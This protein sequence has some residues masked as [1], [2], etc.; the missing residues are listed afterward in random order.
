ML[1]YGKWADHLE[2]VIT[3]KRDGIG[4]DWIKAMRDWQK[5]KS[6]N[7]MDSLHC[8]SYFKRFIKMFS[9]IVT[10]LTNIKRIGMGTNIW[11]DYTDETFLILKNCIIYD[12]TPIS[13]KWDRNYRGYV[14]ASQL[15][16]WA[17]L[18]QINVDVVRRVRDYYKTIF[19][20]RKVLYSKSPRVT[21]TFSSS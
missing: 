2:L 11:N 12:L 20:L 15:T 3:A 18:A 1:V 21:W 7:Y 6:P 16:V 4:S 8:Y 5:Q 9:H 19:Y 14:D 10:L 13:P 17:A